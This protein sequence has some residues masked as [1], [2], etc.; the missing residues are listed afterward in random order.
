MRAGAL[1]LILLEQEDGQQKVGEMVNREDHL[2]A[3]LGHHP[4]CIAQTGVVDQH[5]Q[6]LSHRQ[7]FGG[8]AANLL[9]RR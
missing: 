5:M 2:D 9:L 3:V 7:E 6:R 1:C 8:Y 4:L